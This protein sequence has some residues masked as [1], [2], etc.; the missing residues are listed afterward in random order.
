M[1][2]DKGLIGMHPGLDVGPTRC[3]F[4]SMVGRKLQY[5]KETYMKSIPYTHHRQ[6]M[7]ARNPKTKNCEAP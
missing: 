6:Y 1:T 3:N 7:E 4:V 2:G 5:L